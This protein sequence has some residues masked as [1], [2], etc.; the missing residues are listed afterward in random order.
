MESFPASRFDDFQ[1]EKLN[2]ELLKDSIR[3]N[4]NVLFSFPAIQVGKFRGSARGY[5]ISSLAECNLN[6]VLFGMCDRFQDHKTKFR[7]YFLLSEIK[8]VV[9]SAIQWLH[10]GIRK[11]ANNELIRCMHMDLKPSSIV[12]FWDDGP[13]TRG[14]ITDFGISGVRH[15]KRLDH[16]ARQVT[17]T[18]AKQFPAEYQAPEVEFRDDEVGSTSDVW[19]FGC[20]LLDVVAFMTGASSLLHYFILLIPGMLNIRK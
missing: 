19:S 8:G 7:P 16:G 1:R 3:P 6:E 13:G 4:Q 12:V 18:R 11:S 5:I 9:T 17:P 20:M 14:K 10:A 2:L 15:V